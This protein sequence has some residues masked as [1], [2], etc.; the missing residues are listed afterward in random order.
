M[1]SVDRITSPRCLSEAVYEPPAEHLAAELDSSYGIFTGKADNVAVLKF[2]EVAARWVA[3]EEWHPGVRG[4]PQAGGGVILRI[5]YKHEAELVMDV[6]RHGANVEVLSPE[7]LRG[8]VSQ[9][10]T[11]AAQQYQGCKV[12]RGGPT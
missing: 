2:N 1:F 5:P 7:G 4:E 6:L 3:E 9:A 10:L 8:A 12:G 11:A